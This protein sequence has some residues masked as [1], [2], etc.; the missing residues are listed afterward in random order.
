[1][2]VKFHPSWLFAALYVAFLALVVSS[3]GRLPE[4]LATHFDAAGRANGWSTREEWRGFSLLLG[5]A[6]PLGAVGLFWVI[7]AFPVWT[8]NLP[9]RDYWLAAKRRRATFAWFLRRGWWLGCLELFFFLGI[10]WIVVRAN[11][12]SPP[13]LANGPMFAVAGLFLAGLLLWVVQ[14]HRHFGRLT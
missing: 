9:N 5:T 7:R 8:F 12:V 1:M 10:Q 4:R 6:L 13:T 2:R 3:D 11:A 14:L